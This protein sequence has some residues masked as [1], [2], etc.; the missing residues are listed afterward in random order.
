MTKTDRIMATIRHPEYE[1]DY[2]EAIRTG[3]DAEMQ[4]INKNGS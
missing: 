3:S 1:N 2:Q 4:I